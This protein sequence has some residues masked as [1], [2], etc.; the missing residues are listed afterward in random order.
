MSGN[1]SCCRKQTR[2]GCCSNPAM[3]DG[4]CFDFAWVGLGPAL[5][6]S[7]TGSSS[8]ITR[9]Y[10]SE[11]LDMCREDSQMIARHGL[12]L[13]LIRQLRPDCSGIIREYRAQLGLHE[14]YLAAVE[15]GPIP[16]PRQISARTHALDRPGE[17]YANR[18]LIRY[19]ST[20]RKAQ[21]KFRRAPE[22]GERI[23]YR[24]P[25]HSRRMTCCYAR[26]ETHTLPQ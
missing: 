23:A 22:V 3:L 14:P 24:Q 2:Q 17:R 13:E 10:R 19:A 12:D 9:N 5:A 11:A 7:S 1:L 20:S 21:A 6:R 16:G 18:R 4:M 25:H 26:A 8:D 15:P